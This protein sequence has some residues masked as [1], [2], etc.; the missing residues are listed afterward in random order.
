MQNGKNFAPTD[1]IALRETRY[2]IKGLGLVHPLNW[3]QGSM[4]N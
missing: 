2:G 4:Y 3:P 1:V